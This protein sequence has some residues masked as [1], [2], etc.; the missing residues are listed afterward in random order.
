MRNL[1]G[2]WFVIFLI[3]MVFAVP[4][5]FRSVEHYKLEERYGQEK[6][7]RI[8]EVLGMLSGWGFFGFWIGVWF[9]PQERFLLPFLQD[10]LFIIPFLNLEVSI[11]HAVLFILFLIP[12]LCLGIGGVMQTGLKTAET[13]RTDRIVDSGLYSFVRH[14][15]YLGGIFSHFALTFL[16]SGLYALLA[17]PIIL[18]LNYAISWKEEVELVREFGE[19]YLR[20]QKSVPMLFPWR[21][22][23]RLHGVSNDN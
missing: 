9:A 8:G 18:V 19:E 6:G 13:H 14:P 16:L 5:H 2:L 22:R 17:S 3:G 21:R 1:I 20:Y 7:K 10:L 15:Q 23:L 11:L 4:F 12:G